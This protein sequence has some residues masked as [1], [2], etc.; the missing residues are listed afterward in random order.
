M[1]KPRVSAQVDKLLLRAGVDGQTPRGYAK[2]HALLVEIAEDWGL[3]RLASLSDRELRSLLGP[4]L[5]TI[6]EIKKQALR[7]VSPSAIKDTQPLDSLNEKAQRLLER[8]GIDSRR[9]RKSYPRRLKQL[10]FIGSIYG[11]TALE[12]ATDEE[13]SEQFGLGRLTERQRDTRL[14]NFILAS[15]AKQKTSFASRPRTVTKPALKP[16]LATKE[17]RRGER[18]RKSSRN[19]SARSAPAGHRQYAWQEEATARWRANGMRGVIEAATGSGKT[20]VGMHIA[21]GLVVD[22]WQILIVT[23]SRD[24]IGQWVREAEDLSIPITT[25]LTAWQMVNGGTPGIGVI[26]YARAGSGE[27]KPKPRTAAGPPRLLI[28]DEAHH[29]GSEVQG[30]RVLSMPWNALLGLTATLERSDAGV[31]QITEIVGPIVFRYSVN[32][33]VKDGVLA[34]FHYVTLG[35][36]LEP[37]KQD[38]Y[39]ECDRLVKKWAGKLLAE[40][41]L[42][43]LPANFMQFAQQK[44]KAGSRSA[45]M[46]ISKWNQRK[47]LVASSQS[48]LLALKKLHLGRSSSRLLAFTETEVAAIAAVRTLNE[49]GDFIARL[50]SSGIEKRDREELLNQFAGGEIDGLVAP[51]LLD[52]GINLPEADL[53][54]VL[55]KSSSGVQLVQRLG[56]VLRKKGDGRNAVF[57]TLY[58]RGTYEDPILR[59]RDEEKDARLA[60]VESASVDGRAINLSDTRDDLRRLR[61]LLKSTSGD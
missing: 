61:A 54:I 11:L 25:D 44:S 39:Q 16:A 41:N 24:L 34:P 42:Q 21:Q 35:V 30:K 49:G 10:L 23:Q 60:E 6:A 31:A 3:R 37:V 47:N 28:A 18:A 15:Q 17:K 53:G 58:A 29:L 9:Y 13:L 46:Y 40:S 57:L 45:G 27:F 32:R 4:G 43:K 38:E 33:A 51:K 2:K 56:R 36:E 5:N 8:C 14:I 1:P 22:G 52:E 26:T 48:K 12:Q 55:A 20:R 7:I 50:F 19:A 59:R